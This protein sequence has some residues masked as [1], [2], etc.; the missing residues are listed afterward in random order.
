METI[1]QISL[2]IHFININIPAASIRS[3]Y[4]LPFK[5]ALPLS[6]HLE[7]KYFFFLGILRASA[8]RAELDCWNKGN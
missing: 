7:K 4:I 2:V 8:G 1:V 6:L 3:S 5:P